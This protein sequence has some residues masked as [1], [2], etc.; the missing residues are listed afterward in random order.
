MPTE[1]IS[2][3]VSSLQERKA[4]IETELADIDSRFRAIADVLNVDGAGEISEP[5]LAASGEKMIAGAGKTG[6]KTNHWFGAGEAVALMKRHVRT[7]M[8]TPE[9]VKVLTRAKGYDNGLSGVQAK[10]FQA[11]AYMAVANAVKGGAARKMRDAAAI[12]QRFLEGTHGG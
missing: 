7:P 5:K 8:T 10:R 6:R 4:A 2:Q 12:L 11:T 3:S 1:P 9:I